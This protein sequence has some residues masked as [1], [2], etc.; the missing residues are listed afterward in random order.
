MNRV[1]ARG[2]LAGAIVRDEQ[3]GR[4]FES[5][6]GQVVESSGWIVIWRPEP[7]LVQATTWGK[8]DWREDL[9]A[10]PIRQ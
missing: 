5:T 7:K 8:G 4:W 10:G 3:D 1:M 2:G 6:W 9:V